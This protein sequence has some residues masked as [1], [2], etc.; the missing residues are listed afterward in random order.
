MKTSYILIPAV[1]SGFEGGRG[2][3]RGRRNGRICTG[4]I[5]NVVAGSPPPG[6]EC[7]GLQTTE[8]NVYPKLKRIS[9]FV[10]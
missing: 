1:K 9:L 8:C 3:Q 7:G 5:A 10:R 6:R 2:C 4:I